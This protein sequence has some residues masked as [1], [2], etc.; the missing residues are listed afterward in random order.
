MAD[1]RMGGQIAS[2]H[3]TH[4]AILRAVE[5]QRL[6][7]VARWGGAWT[8]APWGPTMGDESDS[9]APW[10][11][12][13]ANVELRGAPEGVADREWT[14][15]VDL[16]LVESPLALRMVASIDLWRHEVAP[17][18]LARLPERAVP[19]DDAPNEGIAMV[20]EI[21]DAL[22]ALLHAAAEPQAP[23]P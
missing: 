5:E 16:S 22:D 10:L 18:S 20:G 7:F 23:R 19:H 1:Y 21:L 6:R 14:A 17:E 3:A 13:W 15:S 9:D 8:V 12:G 11:Q 2:L 4:A